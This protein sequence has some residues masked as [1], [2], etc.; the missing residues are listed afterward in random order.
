M[1]HM[2]PAVWAYGGDWFN[3]DYTKFTG[4]APEVVQAVQLLWDIKWKIKAEPLA[5]ALP[6]AQQDPYTSLAT[7]GLGLWMQGDWAYGGLRDKTKGTDRATAWDVARLPVGPKGPSAR[8]TPI[9]IGPIY[10]F[11][12]TKVPDLAWEY[13]KFFTSTDTAN[14]HAKL[15]G[16]IPSRKSSAPAALDPSHPPE[17]EQRVLDQLAESSRPMSQPP[18]NNEVMDAFQQAMQAAFVSN[19]ATVPQA[20]GKAKEAVEKILSS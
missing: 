12:A 20:L 17:H 5:T 4:D 14:T 2:T 7:G 10:A 11:K 15:L 18:H 8:S 6:Q 1:W 16:I 19:T 13:I 3:A 9:N